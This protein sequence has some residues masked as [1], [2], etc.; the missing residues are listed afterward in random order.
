MAI[1]P[2]NQLINQ[3]AISTLPPEPHHKPSTC[4]GV[5]HHKQPLYYL[6]QLHALQPTPTQK[7][8]QAAGI[9]N[10]V[11]KQ[12]EGKLPQEMVQLIKL[13]HFR[14]VN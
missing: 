3:H 6:L 11:T 8:N 14:Y 2:K 13:L 4:K 1:Q 9:G 7:N 10:R 12:Q 5:P